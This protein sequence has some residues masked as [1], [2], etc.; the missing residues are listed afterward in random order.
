MKNSLIFIKFSVFKRNKLVE[1][2]SR[3]CQTRVELL[4]S[5]LA[6]FFV[7]PNFVTRDEKH[8]KKGLKAKKRNAF[9]NFKGD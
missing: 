5:N 3:F 8:S 7:Q 2:F 4:L 1:F 6:E 9:Q